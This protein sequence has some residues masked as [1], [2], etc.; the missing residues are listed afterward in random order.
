MNEKS[1]NSSVYIDYLIC[2]YDTYAT[3]DISV[4]TCT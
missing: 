2:T 3:T 1:N 4:S